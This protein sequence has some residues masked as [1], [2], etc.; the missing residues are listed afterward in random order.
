MSAIEIQIGGFGGQGVI[1]AGLT[2][3]R[4]LA[5]YEDYHVSLTQSFGPEARGSA[6]SVQLIVSDAPILYPYLSRP[7]VLV[8]LS[9]EAFRRFA[10][11]V[12]E[13]GRLLV[14]ETLVRPEGVRPD[15]RLWAVP[16]TRLAEELGRKI[17][18]NMVVVGFFA[19]VTGLL[20]PESARRAVSE[21]VPLGTEALNLAAFE[22][23]YACGVSRLAAA[24]A[25]TAFRPLP[26]TGRS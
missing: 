21:S 17:V 15:L 13:G 25:E 9:Q 5:L 23:G 1:L 3:G 22:K 18:L 14:E 19:A 7:D 4:G 11:Q 12:R 10:P 20:R 2:L 6:C 24:G 8:T 16:A 26:L